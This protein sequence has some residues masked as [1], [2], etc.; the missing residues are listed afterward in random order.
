MLHHLL[1]TLV[2]LG[3]DAPAAAEAD[4]TDDAVNVPKLAQGADLSFLIGR[5]EAAGKTYQ[6]LVDA[7]PTIG[8]FW[9]R[10]G[11][12]LLET[13]RY[14]EAIPAF[15]KSL[16]LGSFQL[17]P[18]RPGYRGEAAWGL[19]AAHARLDH[20]EE[21]VQ[22][23]RKSLAQG[24]R[25]IR[26][27]H[28]DHFKNLLADPEYRKLVWAVDD[29]KQLP[30]DEGLRLDLRFLV[31]E[32]KRIHFAP[33]RFSSEKEIDN[34]AAELDRDIPSLTDDQVFVRLMGIVRRFHDGHTNLRR[35]G[36]FSGLPVVFFSFPEGIY[37][38]GAQRDHADLVGASVLRIGDRPIDEV[39]QLAA[40]VQSRDTDIAVPRTIYWLL[41]AP[42]ILRGLGIV[43]GST[44]ALD[45]KDALGKARR[46]EL[47]ETT[48]PPKPADWVCEVPGC[49]RPLPISRSGPPARQWL[50][51]IPEQKTVYCQ[52]NGISGEL[53]GFCN[54]LFAAVNED[55]VEAL[56]LDLR[57]N[58]GGDTFTN[59]PLIE[60]LIRCEKLRH[61]GRLF[62]IIG[63]QTY[64]AAINT[65]T[66][67]ERRTKAIL[68]G[69]PTVC[70]PN[71]IGE[72]VRVIMPYTGWVA[73]ISDL[74]WQ[75]SMPMDYRVWTAPQLYA[76][77]TAEAFLA[78]RDP[79]LEIIW[80]Y[81][82]A[83]GP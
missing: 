13:G 26:Q 51:K 38:V 49:E 7:N 23:T 12:C 81:R 66:E 25:Q 28:T 48:K 27:F 56:V 64:S 35:V 18:V 2:L 15:E 62:L 47:A 22:W 42:S 73:S 57:Y 46:V 19:A 61:P 50:Q 82:A 32:A 30:R 36:H 39:I 68:V 58:G 43:S 17:N 67:I 70:P 74:W 72:S 16:E 76:P 75:H 34:L 9:Y 6:R 40:D 83:Q 20:A 10:L 11:V 77:P 24:L 52:I 29:P 5:W 59:P 4:R 1:V 41:H 54:K 31:H 37:I 60:G 55:D 8:L 21:A 71:F 53:G 69:E 45:V 80:R 3:A 14:A 63:R 78:H 65:T 33:F 44:V 79:A